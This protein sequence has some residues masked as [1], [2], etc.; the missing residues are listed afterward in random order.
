MPQRRAFVS[1]LASTIVGAV[2]IVIAPGARAQRPAQPIARPPGQRLAGA[3]VAG[4]FDATG[5]VATGA[6]P[7]V[8][9]VV[10]VDT[11]SDT[12]QLRDETGRAGVVHVKEHTFELESLKAG[13]EVEV[14]FVVPEPGST[15]LE[16][17]GLWKV[18]R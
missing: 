18:Q 11:R 7:G 9:V 16:A 3:L 12:L 10:A 6:L 14:D 1:G 2:L 8:Y 4:R 15:R 17:G 13:D 5:G